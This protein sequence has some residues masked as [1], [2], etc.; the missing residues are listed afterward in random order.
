MPKKNGVEVLSDLL[1]QKH[2][3]VLMISSLNLEEGSLVF[4][5]L[6]AGAFDYIQKPR[7]EDREAFKEEILSKALLAVEGR[8]AHSSLR[9]LNSPKA[10]AVNALAN[11]AYPQNLVWCMGAST[12]GTQ[13]LTRV[14][15]S[16][17]SEIPPTLIV[18]HIPPIFSKAFADSL[19]SLC[20]FTVTEAQ[21]GDILE[22]N[23]AYVAP[24]GKQMRINKSGGNYVIVLSD[25]APVNRFKP[26]VDYLFKQLAQIRDLKFVA[27]IFTGMGR[28]GAEGL[29]ALR[30]A[31]AN[32]FAQ[33]ESSSTVYG[34][35]R[36]AV[37]LKAPEHVCHIDQVAQHLLSLSLL[38]RAG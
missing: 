14:F 23:H 11:I 26:S 27:G 33:D 37:E 21:D 32:T 5:A 9:K 2:F 34:M 28:D 8:E 7:L 15:T 25:D 22:R 10:N 4:D 17:P 29:L 31:G 3:P 13:A 12:G 19:N 6:N 18:Q 30:K 35:P 38:K 1:S 24:G 16:L 20:P 36:A